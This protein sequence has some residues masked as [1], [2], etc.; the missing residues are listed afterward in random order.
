MKI[1]KRHWLITAFHPF[2]G[3]PANNS[4]SVLREIEKLAAGNRGQMDWP[5]EI[6]TTLLPVEYDHCHTALMS[7]VE[8]LAARGIHLEGV[9]SLGEGAEE[10]KLETQANNVDDVPE[11]ADNKGVIRSG[12]KIFKDLD[13][14]DKI[15][16]RFP[17][18]AFNR[19][20]SSVSPGFYICNHLCARMGREWSKKDSPWFGFIHVPRTGMGGLFTSEVCANVIVNG[21]KKIKA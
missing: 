19:I 12:Q 11:L 3:R 9:L 17:F 13:V 6:H 4:E 5:F 14:T 20:R 18:E 8:A 15:P 21:F 7:E 16:L 10:F 2:A 1:V